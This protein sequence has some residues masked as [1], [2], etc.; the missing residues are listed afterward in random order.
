ML[1]EIGYVPRN[2]APTGPNG[3]KVR[4]AWRD[5]SHGYSATWL[6]E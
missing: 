6:E 5:T 3:P 4:R 2:P 1:E